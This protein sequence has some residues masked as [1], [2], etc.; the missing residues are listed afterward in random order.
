MTQR[1]LVSLK[2]LQKAVHRKE[3]NVTREKVEFEDSRR[4]LEARLKQVKREL[5]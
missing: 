1:F 2:K 5:D 3:S 4:E